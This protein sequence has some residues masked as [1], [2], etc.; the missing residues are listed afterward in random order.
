MARMAERRGVG[1]VLVGNSEGTRPLRRTSR[2]WNNRI[3]VDHNKNSWVGVDWI[4]MAQDKH[5]WWAVVNAFMNL[6]VS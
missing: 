3:S 2:K 1:R 6:R 4:D 5:K